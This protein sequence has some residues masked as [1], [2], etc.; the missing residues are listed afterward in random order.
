MMQIEFAE[1]DPCMKLKC[2]RLIGMYE[3]SVQMCGA[4]LH[5]LSN[6]GNVTGLRLK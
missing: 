2:R 3:L 5:N 4:D 1:E 6:L